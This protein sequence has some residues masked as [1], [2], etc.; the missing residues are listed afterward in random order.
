[1]LFFARNVQVKCLASFL[2]SGR[3]VMN[4]KPLSRWL[5]IDGNNTMRGPARWAS[6]LGL[7]DR[8]NRP[9]DPN[10]VVDASLLGPDK[11]RDPLATLR[12]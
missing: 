1:M 4:C 11:S 10:D 3:R 9:A 5:G 6:S 12:F 2:D 7:V 8:K